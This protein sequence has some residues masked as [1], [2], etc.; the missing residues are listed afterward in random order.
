M[1]RST[2]LQLLAHPAALS[3]ADVRELEQLAQA[4]PYCQ[5]AH[6]L[7]A[8]AAH[9]QGSMLAGQRLRRAATYATNRAL[10]RQLIE[11]PAPAEALVAE[12]VPAML[13]NA[14][15]TLPNAD[16]A[17][18]APA[19]PQ[20]ALAAPDAALFEVEHTQLPEPAN[21]EL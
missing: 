15:A 9:D 17:A 20:P 6:L 19:E 13:V 2:L 5:T 7:L 14:S 1:T 11:Q 21:E 16:L 4:F 10:L 12:A 18:P 8:K 3:G